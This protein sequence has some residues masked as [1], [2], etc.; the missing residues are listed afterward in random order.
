LRFGE[1]IGLAMREEHHAED[2]VV[3]YERGIMY[4]EETK[5]QILTELRT[6]QPKVI[7]TAAQYVGSETRKEW[8]CIEL[9]I[10]LQSYCYTAQSIYHYY[11]LPY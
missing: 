2:G 7:I 8:K 5:H 1:W 11:T 10:R 4:T 6:R 9:E 3:R